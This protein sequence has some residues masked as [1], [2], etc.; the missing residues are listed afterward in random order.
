ME[1]KQFDEI[2]E[3]HLKRFEQQVDLPFKKDL[4]KQ[5]SFVRDGILDVDKYMFAP[6]K[7]L[8]VLKEPNSPGD[9]IGSDMRPCLTSLRSNDDTNRIAPGWGHT[10]TPVAYTT[11]GIFEKKNWIDIPDI[12]GNAQEVLKHMPNIAHINVKK[13]AGGSKT[14]DKVIKMFFDQYKALIYEQIEIINPDVIIFGSTF[15]YFSDYFEDKEKIHEW[16]PVYQS[17]DKLLIDTCHPNGLRGFKMTQ[18]EYCDHIID[19]VIQWM[20]KR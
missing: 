9:D 14:K 16:P 11:Y 12:R 2:I 3:E 13:F 4:G 6:V 15:K 7:I 18:Q 5:M 1:K 20:E 8:W 17:Q 10:W 19:T